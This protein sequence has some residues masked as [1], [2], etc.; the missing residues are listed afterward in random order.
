MPR[1]PESDSRDNYA[2]SILTI[3]GE[4]MES[5]HTEWKLW[6]GRDLLES[7]LKGLLLGVDGG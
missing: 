3:A 4:E 1:A 2:S 5:K 7:L 6:N